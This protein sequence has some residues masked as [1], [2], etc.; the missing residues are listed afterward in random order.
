MRRRQLRCGVRGVGFG[1]PNL[2]DIREFVLMCCDSVEVC[3]S[4]TQF[5]GM[6]K[7]RRE[8][9]GWA[10]WSLE[11]PGVVEFLPA[12]DREVEREEL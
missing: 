2:E 8:H 3:S 10:G 12:R 7:L 4:I 9:S 5:S 6:R 1:D 11:Q